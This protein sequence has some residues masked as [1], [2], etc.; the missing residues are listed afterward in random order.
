[1]QKTFGFG[2]L[3]NLLLAALNGMVYT[4]GSWQGGKFAQKHG[5]VFSITLGVCGVC[6]ALFFGGLVHTII[7][8]IIGYVL[9]TISVCFI[10]PAL[11]AIVSDNAGN[12]LSKMV[13]LYNVTWAGTG[14]VSYFITGILLEKLGMQSL[15]WLPFGLNLLQLLVVLPFATAALRIE[16]K[17]IT[18]N[19]KKIEVQRSSQSKK[20][21]YMSWLA[22]PFSY[23]AISTVIPLI[24][25]ISGRFGLSTGLA[26]VFCSVW[27]FARLGAFF[28]LWKWPGWH[29]RFS[30]MIGAFSVMI[31][32]YAGILLSNSII[33]LI[34]AQIGF[35]IS[36]GIL[37]YSSLYYSMDVS[38]QK[39]ANGGLHEAMIGTGL[40]IGPA[41]GAACLYFVPTA[42]GIS[43]M[44]VNGLLLIGFSGLLWMGSIKKKLE[45]RIENEVKSGIQEDFTSP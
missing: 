38:E 18:G 44:P 23:V 9:W 41:F 2:D 30:W 1:M 22:N 14:A 5:S 7:A 21:L 45:K 32:C 20:F 11:E 25:S 13:G 43:G 3:E 40:F 19:P 35:G 28:A 4:V 31:A 6:G 29:Y 26:G 8:Q 12:S 17:E 33:M 42:T 36:I 24:P 15:F 39:G 34:F 37:Y 10:W 27:M 16:K